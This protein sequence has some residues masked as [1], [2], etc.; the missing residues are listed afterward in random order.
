M[1]TLRED[2]NTYLVISRSVLLKIKNVSANVVKEIKTHILC[3]LT[4]SEYRAVYE[5]MWK[6]TVVRGKARDYYMAHAHCILYN[7]GDTQ[8]HNMSY[9]LIFHCNNCCNN[10][11]E[12]YVIRTLSVLQNFLIL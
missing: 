11:H 8:T 5:V 4:F 2:Q 10:P 6:D 12:Y 3:S 9:L 1:C 7:K